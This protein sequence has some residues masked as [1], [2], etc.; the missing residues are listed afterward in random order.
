MLPLT[1]PAVGRPSEALSRN[2]LLELF[3]YARLNARRRRAARDPVPPVPC[4]PPLER[5]FM[6]GV[7]KVVDAVRTLV[8]Y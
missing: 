5:A 3:Y 8:R 6:P 1:A 2:Q 4:S 7:D